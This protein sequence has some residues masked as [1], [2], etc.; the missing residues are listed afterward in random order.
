M[1]LSS[2]WAITIIKS[3]LSGIERHLNW[4]LVFNSKSL[5]PAYRMKGKA[6]KTYNVKQNQWTYDDKTEI[7]TTI[8]ILM[9][10]HLHG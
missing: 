9:S 6:A 4:P 10:G 1:D 8:Y 2:A 7:Q 3:N 5:N